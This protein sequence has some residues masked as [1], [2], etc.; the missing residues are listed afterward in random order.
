MHPGENKMC[1]DL[2]QKCLK[3][4]M[5]KDISEYVAACLT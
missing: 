5:K 1:K 4:G 3:N 2:K